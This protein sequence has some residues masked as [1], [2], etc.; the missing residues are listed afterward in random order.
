MNF[1]ATLFRVINTSEAA[2]STDDLRWFSLQRKVKE[3]TIKRVFDLFRSNGIEPVLIKGWAAARNYR[4][5]IPRDYIDTDIAVAASDYDQARQICDSNASEG[6]A[7]DLHRELRHLDSLPWN[8][9]FANSD[10]VKID[11]SDIRVLRPEDHLRVLCIHWLNDGGANKI[12]LWDI[13]Y[14][15]ANRPPDFGWTRCLETISEYRRRWIITAIAITHEYLGL[16][17]D[18]LPFHEEAATV[19]VWIRKCLEREWN[20]TVRLEPVI[21]HLRSPSS[22]A[23]QIVK[24]IPPNPLRA[25]IEMEG[26]IDARTRIFYQIG[27]FA[28]LLANPLR[29]RARRKQFDENRK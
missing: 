15:V 27:C 5:D 23:Q 6:L 18:D 8:D 19:P 28:R 3:D 2:I 20:S 16:K 29:S 26:R 9:L 14:A 24:R 10:I 17:V 4:E 22:L 12:R 13:Y 25:T 11:D 7:I 1:I 21:M